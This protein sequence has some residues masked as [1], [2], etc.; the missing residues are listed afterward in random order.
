[1]KCNRGM[2]SKLNGCEKTQNAMLRYKRT[3]HKWRVMETVPY[4]V[5]VHGVAT[6]A[7]RYIKRKSLSQQF[8]DGTFFPC[9]EDDGDSKRQARTSNEIRT[10]FWARL[11][12]GSSV[13]AYP[14]KSNTSRASATA[15]VMAAAATMT[16]LMRMVRPTGLP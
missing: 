8:A 16:G 11:P 14:Q 9:E 10:F 7:R 1:M 15:P 4:G 5:N 3:V 2:R 6:S 13:Q 12:P